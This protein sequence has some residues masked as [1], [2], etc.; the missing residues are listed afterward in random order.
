MNE[1]RFTVEERIMECWRVVDDIK[2]TWEE[3]SDSEEEM[4]TD[5]LCNILLGMQ[6]LYDRKFARLFSSYEKMLE[7]MRQEDVDTILNSRNAMDDQTFI[8]RLDVDPLDTT[9]NSRG[10]DIPINHVNLRSTDMKE[11][12]FNG[13]TE[14]TKEKIL[15]DSIHP[16]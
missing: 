15:I 7:E 10:T 3:F 5:E 6:T 4:D 11:P 1:A 12:N 13:L 8:D 2:V 14:S 9:F 16:H